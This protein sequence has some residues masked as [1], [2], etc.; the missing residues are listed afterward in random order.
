M[1]IQIFLAA[2]KPSHVL[3]LA[4]QIIFLCFYCLLTLSSFQKTKAKKDAFQ[5]GDKE[6]YITARA[7]LKAG[8][9]EA[10]RRHRQGPERDLNNFSTKDMWQVIQNV[11][12]V[13]SRSAPH[14]VRSSVAGRTFYAPVELLHLQKTS[15][16][17]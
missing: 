5:S 11:T 15:H 17:R 16:C 8:I 3:T 14:H 12:G 9:E 1:C 10:K 2:T 4:Y 7:G 13:K 6:A